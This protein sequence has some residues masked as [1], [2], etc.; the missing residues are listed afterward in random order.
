MSKDIDLPEINGACA[1]L[2]TLPIFV[3]DGALTVDDI[4]NRAHTLK[5]K[6]GNLELIVIDYI[7][8]LKGTRRVCALTSAEAIAEASHN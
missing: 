6:Q 3:Q 2:N 8:L 7:G 1:R 4:R 5:L